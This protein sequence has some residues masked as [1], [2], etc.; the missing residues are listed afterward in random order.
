[1][2]KCSS[3]NKAAFLSQLETQEQS[4]SAEQVKTR[5]ETYAPIEV[6]HEKA[7]KWYI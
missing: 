2:K 4:L 7:P 3:L 6:A 5:L 1:M